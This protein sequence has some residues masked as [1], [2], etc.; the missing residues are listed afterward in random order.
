MF[1]IFLSS[2]HQ[3]AFH[4]FLIWRAGQLRASLL[5]AK[6]VDWDIMELRSPV[7][8]NF[9]IPWLQV[10]FCSLY[11]HWNLLCLYYMKLTKF[12]RNAHT[13]K[14]YYK[15]LLKILLFPV[16]CICSNI[17]SW[18]HSIWEVRKKLLPSAFLEGISVTQSK[19]LWF[20]K[21]LFYGDIQWW[22]EHS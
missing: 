22:C 10:F 12:S 19:Y 18:T 20:G 4:D 15:Y 7:T 8:A 21:L 14:S 2:W 6:V 16:P 1:I 5:L 17:L 3:W 13:D 9:P 11:V